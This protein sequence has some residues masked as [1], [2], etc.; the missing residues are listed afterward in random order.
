ME[1]VKL[2]FKLTYLIFRHRMRIFI[3]VFLSKFPSWIND[4]IRKMECGLKG[5]TY[6][7]VRKNIGKWK[8]RAIQIEITYRCNLLC[9]NCNRHCNLVNLPYLKDSDMSI[10]QIK[11]FISQV[12]EKNVHLDAVEVMGGEPL[13]HPHIE[14]IISLL[15]YGLLVPGYTIYITVSSNGV[16]K[17]RVKRIISDH[18]IKKA[19]E[20]GMITMNYVPGPK[21]GRFYCALTAPVDLGLPFGWCAQPR[22]CGTL[23][24]C[25]GYW[26]GGPC[27]AIARMFRLTQYAR[28]DFPLDFAET[29][30]RLIE[31]ICRYCPLG[32]GDLENRTQGVVTVSYKKAIESWMKGEAG[33]F[34]KF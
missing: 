21:A 24:N 32:C 25:D 13:L 8:V 5:E 20:N 11:K 3:V 15:F 1:S 27:G 28:Y 4:G 10:G 34:R 14:E 26:P 7:N 23:L 16:F 22:A 30:P 6:P 12:K 31:D 18:N 17:D 29:W 33:A 9:R 19:F 2:K